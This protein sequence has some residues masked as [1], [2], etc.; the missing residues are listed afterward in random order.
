MS[1]QNVRGNFFPSG[2][3]ADLLNFPDAGSKYLKRKFKVFYLF[4]LNYERIRLT[5]KLMLIQF[6]NFSGFLLTVESFRESSMLNVRCQKS[7]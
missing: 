4:N 7:E 2:L 5:K 1:W 3:V 6:V